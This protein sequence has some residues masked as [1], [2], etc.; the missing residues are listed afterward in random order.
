LRRGFADQRSEDSVDKVWAHTRIT[1]RKWFEAKPYFKEAIQVPGSGEIIG[2]AKG[3]ICCRREVSTG[4]LSRAA[5][6]IGAC[7][8]SQF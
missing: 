1:I 6:Q 3:M 4:Q 8:S 2:L 7:N 5:R